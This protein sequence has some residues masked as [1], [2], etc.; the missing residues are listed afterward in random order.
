M[1]LY[2]LW[3]K[4][5]VYLGLSINFEA[6]TAC[7]VDV[8]LE[9]KKVLDVC[10]AAVHP[11]PAG[12]AKERTD[13]LGKEKRPKNELITAYLSTVFHSSVRDSMKCGHHFTRNALG[14]KQI[15]S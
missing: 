3:V 5:G 14:Q 13:S 4:F 7:D 15:E 12:Q 10:Y 8:R 11:P 2:A 6:V 1:V 9:R